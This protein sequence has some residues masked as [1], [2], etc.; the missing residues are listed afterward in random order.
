MIGPIDSKPAPSFKPIPD[1]P[2]EPAPRGY[3]TSSFTGTAVGTFET[4]DGASQTL[5]FS[6]PESMKNVN[7]IALWISD[8]G[9]C[10]FYSY[11]YFYNNSTK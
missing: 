7:P 9:P 2:K 5:T 3:V 10:G 1:G 11:N 6:I 8:N 4:G